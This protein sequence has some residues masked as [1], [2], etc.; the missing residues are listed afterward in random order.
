MEG[1]IDIHGFAERLRRAEEDIRDP[2][3]LSRHNAE[4]ISRFAEHCTAR[5]LGKARIV[6]YLGHLR[7]IA[8]WLGKDLEGATRQD[9]ERLVYRIETSEYSPWTKM[10]YKVIIKRFYK[11]LLGKD[12]EYPPEVKWIKTT[13]KEKDRLLPEELLTEGEIK[14]FVSAGTNPRDRAFLMTLYESGGR[15]GEVGSLRIRDIEFKRGYASIMLQGKTGARRVPVMAS[16]PYLSMWLEHHPLRDDPN[17][18]LWVKSDNEP[19]TYPALAKVLKVAARRA[20]LKKRVSPHKLRHSRATF[21]ASK[22]TE[23]QMNQLFGWKQGSDMPSTY[24][25]LSGRDVDNAILGIYGLR[26]A[27]ETKPSEL[28]PV[29]CPR[30]KLANP[31]TGKFCTNCGMALS[32][33]AATA[34]GQLQ[35]L[36]LEK[37]VRELERAQAILASAIISVSKGSKGEL[38]VGIEKLAELAKKHRRGSEG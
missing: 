10:D 26:E 4:L 20:G 12:E 18:P 31:A 9:I 33:E 28:T 38:V 34:S 17:A 23:A 36:E 22:L 32:I 19:M 5:G 7:R 6:K 21:L 13:M 14:R 29:E 30:C 37:K 2:N 35:E 11:W 15:I 8:E 24:V 1:R 27:E 3:P 25:H 16:V